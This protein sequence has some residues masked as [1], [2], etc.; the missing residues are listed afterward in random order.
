M[1]STTF[2]HAELIIKEEL[3]EQNRNDIEKVNWSIL[4]VVRFSYGFM[5]IFEG[6]DF[7]EDR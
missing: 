3:D 5:G 6:Y 4:N 1:C 2:F 7:G